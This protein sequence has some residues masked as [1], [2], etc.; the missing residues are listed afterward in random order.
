MHNML[1]RTKDQSIT[2]A[3]ATADINSP[4]WQ[5]L[6]DRALARD[7]RFL[8]ALDKSQGEESFNTLAGLAGGTNA[9]EL[10][11][12]L[13]AGKEATRNI[14]TPM[15]DAALS[16][17]NLGKE[18]ARLESLSAELGE[19][20]SA[21]VQE[22]RR[23]MELG[24]LAK[25]NARLSMIKRDLPVG[26]A[27]YTYFGELGDKAFNEWS[28]KAASASLD[29]GQGARFAKDAANNLR[30]MGI[31]PL[32]S[33][34]LV[35]S[36]KVLSNNPEFAGNDVLIG[37][38][39]NVSDDISKWTDSGG[40][41]DARAL[42]AIRENSVNAAIQQLRP[43]MDA[44]SQRNLAAG[45]LSK[46]RPMIDD[47]IEAAGGEGYK[48]YL[49]EHARLSQEVAEKQLT[50]EALKLWNTD[51]KAFVDLVQNQSP[52]MVEEVLGPRKYDIATNLPKEAL[53]VLQSEA[54]KA[55]RNSTVAD[56]ADKGKDALRALL[57]RDMSK[58]R[59]PSYLS[60]L[61]STTNKA[62]DIIENRI[63]D[64]T[65]GILTE[66]MKTPNG[67]VNLLESLPAG[68]RIR[69]LSILRNPATWGPSG[70]AIHTG[71]TI[72]GFNALFP[73][74]NKENKLAR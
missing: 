46:T 70:R 59:L 18:V 7:P 47:A 6:N 31:K 50:G 61:T 30:S 56:Q 1:R 57:M 38:L 43:G 14:T 68:E 4:T 32:K 65:M 54:S 23:L 21:K 44:T 45:I 42:G 64:K 16:R 22:V 36:L 26:L 69:V 49:N 34:P 9:A 20:A 53:D 58:I 60:A 27:R 63:G 67:A 40:V 2:A 33:E 11:G 24:E 55:V 15:R 72:A 73:D 48:G 28:N 37:S 74:R 71:G 35:R 8:N 52:E 3:Q 13:E 12:T 25:A 19:Q 10:R 29:L 41:I 66:A 62:L 51:K 5:A 39:R 17:A